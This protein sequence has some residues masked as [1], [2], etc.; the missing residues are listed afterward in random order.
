M[1]VMHI[2]KSF[3]V[4]T[5]QSIGTVP[6]HASIPGQRLVPDCYRSFLELFASCDLQ[7]LA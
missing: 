4:I 6:A 7:V 2:I 3:L 5:H 1:R